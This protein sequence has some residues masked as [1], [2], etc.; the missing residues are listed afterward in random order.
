MEAVW[1]ITTIGSVNNRYC[2]KDLNK[3]DKLEKRSLKRLN[4]YDLKNN[5]IS[6]VGIIDGK[7]Y[8]F[9]LDGD[10]PIYV[11]IHKH[12][13]KDNDEAYDH[14]KSKECKDIDE[15]VLYINNLFNTVLSTV[16]PKHFKSGGN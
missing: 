5:N 1:L 3:G 6:G 7:E 4:I 15:A 16:R 9:Y 8:E 10:D 12:W 11:D 14:K 13:I 2:F